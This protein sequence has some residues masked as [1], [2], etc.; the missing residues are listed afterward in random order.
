MGREKYI[1]CLLC[2]ANKINIINEFEKQVSKLTLSQFHV[3]AFMSPGKRAEAYIDAAINPLISLFSIPLPQQ[4][5]K[6]I[7][8]SFCAFVAKRK[9]HTLKIM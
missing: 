8:Y 5:V 6:V 7:C 1:K 4:G 9:G 3:I 2:F